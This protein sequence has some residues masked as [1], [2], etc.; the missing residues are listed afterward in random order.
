MAGLNPDLEVSIKGS[1]PEHLQH[2]L[3]VAERLGA[4]FLRVVLSDANWKPCESAALAHCGNQTH[5]GV[6]AHGADI[7][8]HL[9]CP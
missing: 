8:G 3:D 7:M 1:Q 9:I 6:V 4:R 2:N 5:I